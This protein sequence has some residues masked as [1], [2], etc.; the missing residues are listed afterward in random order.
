MSWCTTIDPA[1]ARPLSEIF[2]HSNANV[3]V[4][5]LNTINAIYV[6][7]VTLNRLNSGE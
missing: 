1:A 4:S 2:I 3:T 7:R 5:Y 6:K